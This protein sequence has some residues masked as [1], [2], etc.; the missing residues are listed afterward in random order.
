MAVR[1]ETSFAK[2][3]KN[4]PHSHTQGERVQSSKYTHD[5]TQLIRSPQGNV[6]F[7]SEIL[8]LATFQEEISFKKL[9][10]KNHPYRLKNRSTGKNK[11]QLYG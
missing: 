5:N 4:C 8:S 6:S 9:T 1:T 2:Q 11:G 3:F 10:Y 7:E